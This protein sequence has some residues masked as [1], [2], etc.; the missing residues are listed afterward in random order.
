[1]QHVHAVGV[2]GEYDRL[3]AGDDVA[4][5][6]L[7]Q[8]AQR[9]A[10]IG[11]DHVDLHARARA[12]VGAREVDR[13]VVCEIDKLDHLRVGEVEIAPRSSGCAG[14]PGCPLGEGPPGCGLTAPLPRGHRAL[15]E[16]REG[17]ALAV[18]RREDVRER[19]LL[20]V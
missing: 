5:L 14:A 20:P 18:E 7:A 3:V 4:T 2:C 11:V 12:R 6:L 17:F 13:V 10:R 16:P 9:D 15:D 8:D 19:E 1:M